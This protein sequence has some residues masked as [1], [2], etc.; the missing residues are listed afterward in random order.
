MNTRVLVKEAR[1]LFWP[2]CAV[3]LAG[4]VSLIHSAHSQDWIRPI[5]LFL[6][7]PL[8]A[9]LPLGNEFQSR[10]LSLLLSQPV[11][12]IK[13]WAEKLF[14][15]FAA[16]AS[17]ALVFALSPLVRESLPDL[18]QRFAAA[19][20]ILA[21]VASATF[22]TLLAR[23]TMGGIVLSVGALLVIAAAVNLVTG[24]GGIESLLSA[25]L[26]VVSIGVMLFYATLMLW[27]GQ[28]NFAR[29]QVKGNSAGDDLLTAG[30]DVMPGVFSDW[31]RSRPAG[32]TLNLIR[33]EL[34]LLR[35]IWLVTFLAA[36]SWTC[37][38]VIELLRREKS[39]N[40]LGLAASLFMGVACAVIVAI[41]AGCLSLGEEKTSGAYAWHRTL[42]VSPL[43]QWL[44]KLFVAMSA[45]LICAGLIPVLL[46]AAGR[47]FFPQAFVQEDAHFRMLWL[48]GMLFLTALS[49]WCACAVTGTVPAV[50]WVAA[51]LLVFTLVPE[52]GNWSAFH[53][54]GFFYS[55]IDLFTN[56]RF[57]VAVSK[58]FGQL[59]LNSD[60]IGY[61]YLT[62]FELAIVWIPATILAVIQTYRLFSAPM[63]DATLSVVRKLSPLALVLFLCSLG[64]SA[65]PMLSD[66]ASARLYGSVYSIHGAAQK[67]LSDSANREAAQPLQL[68]TDDLKK[69][70]PP[71]WATQPRW[72][73]TASITVTADKAHP[74]TCCATVR[75]GRPLWNYTAVV[76]LAD[77]ATMTVWYEPS[78]DEPTGP[79]RLNATVRWPNSSAEEPFLRR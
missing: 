53:L 68:T 29:Y 17:A 5:A 64:V 7:I 42:P 15:S 36:S 3:T 57:T 34:R 39:A 44:V 54:A 76:H 25:H 35:P 59:G 4:I 20:I 50:L 2:W 33:K 65:L 16:V 19:A 14:V 47:H 72:L 38:T 31:F 41:L 74:T 6:G 71:F 43:R 61:S 28:R 60:R 52:F 12:R 63:K 22:W 51:L 58:L 79:P 73:Y 77:G 55:K 40:D 32:A 48:L 66:R 49:F 56:F 21:V 8:L 37:F 46:M 13:I 30:P 45:S 11:A 27:L 24:I 26:A 9:T 67:L 1:P 18:S 23:S 69:A 62:I 75:F 78:S 10:T 70:S